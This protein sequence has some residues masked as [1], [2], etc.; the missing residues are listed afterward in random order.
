MGYSCYNSINRKITFDI[1]FKMEENTIFT[2]LNFPIESCNHL[3]DNS[4]QKLLKI[5]HSLDCGANRIS[6][7]RWIQ[8][9]NCIWT[10]RQLI[11]KARWSTTIQEETILNK[12]KGGKIKDWCLVYEKQLYTQKKLIHPFQYFYRDDLNNEILDLLQVN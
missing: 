12:R 10:R 9:N 8:G 2:N 5:M 3:I 11:T 7:F 1:R 6:Y 4:M